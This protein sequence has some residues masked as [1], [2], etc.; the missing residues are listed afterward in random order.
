MRQR[1]VYI[2]RGPDIRVANALVITLN[3][4]TMAEWPYDELIQQMK[5]TFYSLRPP[6]L[7]ANTPIAQPPQPPVST[8]PPSQVPTVRPYVDSAMEQPG[9]YYQP[10]PH[11]PANAITKLSANTNYYPFEMNNNPFGAQ[12]GPL[13]QMRSHQ[14]QFQHMQDQRQAY[15][16]QFGFPNDQS[17]SA[18][19]KKSLLTPLERQNIQNLFKLKKIYTD[20]MRYHGLIDSF[21]HKFQKFE[22]ACGK[23]HINGDQARAHIFPLHLTGDAIGYYEEF[24]H[25]HKNTY[26]ETVKQ[27]KDFFETPEY[28]AEIREEYNSITLQAIINDNTGKSKLECLTELVAKITDLYRRLPKPRDKEGKILPRNDDWEKM[29]KLL[30]A[31]RTDPDCVNATAN[32]GSTFQGHHAKLRQSIHTLTSLSQPRRTYKQHI[33]DGESSATGI[34]NLLSQIANCTVIAAETIRRLNLLTPLPL[35]L[36][37]RLALSAIR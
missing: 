12:N 13:Q 20:E 21:D 31:C 26:T 19:S 25:G 22:E 36:N 1:G 14:H 29:E 33:A 18:A 34:P 37:K 24:V 16:D 4:P 8:T 27:F 5:T 11:R 6:T 7:R 35:P 2:A 30:A 9:P 3:E 10:L 23:V 28:L 32:P 15:E 17:V